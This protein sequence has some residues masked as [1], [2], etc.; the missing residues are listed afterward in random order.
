MNQ[1]SIPRGNRADVKTTGVIVPIDQFLAGSMH[2]PRT[3]CRVAH[4]SRNIFLRFDVRD[5]Y[6]RCA[7]RRFQGP[8]WCDSCVEFFVRPR[9]DK[10]YFNF[11]FNCGGQVL[12]YYVT[13]WRRRPDKKFRKST[14]LEKPEAAALQIETKLRAPIEPEITKPTAWWLEATIP[15]SVLERYVG[16]LGELPGQRWR[17][18]LQKC[19]NS[20]S[21]P[22]WATWNNIGEERNF[23]QPDKFG[24]LRFK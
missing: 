24:E 16:Q 20:T 11:E 5:R 6:V 3:T 13:D 10:G 17:A 15:L 18:N 2:R 19:G 14:P 1:L 22:H 9:Q 4:D 8:V 21:H 12:A 7:N 23:H